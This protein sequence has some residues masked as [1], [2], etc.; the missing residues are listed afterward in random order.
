M[1]CHNPI[2]AYRSRIT[3]PTGRRSLVFNKNE[4]YDDLEILVP[5][6]QCIGCKLDRSLEWATRI[7]HEASLHSK[8]SFVTLTY[9]DRQLPPHNSLRKKDVQDFLKRLRFFSDHP[10]RYY[11]CGEYGTET[12]RPH[13]HICLFGEDFSYDRTLW[14]TSKQG[15]AYYNSPSLDDRWS[16]GHC[17]VADL[18]FETAA[19]TARYV[20]KKINGEK[21]ASHYGLREPEFSLMSRRPGIGD[22]WLKKNVVDLENGLCWSSNGLTKIPKFYQKKINQQKLSKLKYKQKKEALKKFRQTNPY[23]LDDV[24]KSKFNLKS[25]KEI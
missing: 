9:E 17:I 6:G 16:F 25:K 10:L 11:L 5:C 21:A 13:Y 3:N 15:F 14:K 20:T 12:Q 23:V 2:T 1:P 4:G 22:D 19:Y 8:S 18:T 7:S 24:Q